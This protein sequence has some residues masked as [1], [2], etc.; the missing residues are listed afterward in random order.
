MVIMDPLKNIPRNKIILVVFAV[1]F[2]QL[3]LSTYFMV[4]QK[5][6]YFADD[7][8]SYG[9]ANSPGIF[10]PLKKD[11]IIVHNEWFNGSILSEYLTVSPDERF[12]FDRINRSLEIDAHP[13]LF[14]YLL[15]AICSLT[16]GVFSNWSAYIINIF[17]FIILQIY[18]YRL[19]LLIGKNRFVAF[20][21]MVFFGFTSAT[22][23]MMVLFRMH[24][25]AT[26]FTV[27]FSFYA[28]RYLYDENNTK[29]LNRDLLLSFVFL[30]L[31]SMT[32]YLSVLFAFFLTAYICLMFIIK[33]N[34]RKM[35]CFGFAMLISVGLMC[36]C[37]PVVF[38]QLFSDLN[39]VEGS[40]LY[41]FMLQLRTCIYVISN[42]VFGIDTP[43]FPS[44]IPFYTLTILI[45]LAVILAVVHF[46]F[47]NDQW[48][49]DLM[50]NMKSSLKSLIKRA[51]P[52]LLSL[53]PFAVIILIFMILYSR[54]LKIFYYK[55]YA[56]RYFYILTPFVAMIVLIILLKLIKPIY[57]RIGIIMILLTTSLLFGSK[58]YLEKE[59]QHKEI[60]AQTKDSDVIVIENSNPLFMYHI[61]DLIDCDRFLY[62]NPKDIV[63]GKVKKPLLNSQNDSI[64]LLVDTDATSLVPVKK[65]AYDNTGTEVSISDSENDVI[66]YFRSLPGFENA[67]L[68]DSYHGCYLYRL[69]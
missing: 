53:L 39:A 24:I 30:Y 34:I 61:M 42:G 41:P 31:S 1:I 19:S 59:L 35:F 8:Y 56:M 44:M 51:H 17:G 55:A 18:L 65:K 37:F 28:L 66:R 23:N 22:V 26:G 54:N 46:I 4:F 45:G 68:I 47:R 9:F 49:K 32:L 58:C 7:L 11:D 48:F 6:G 5:T 27:A 50:T 14:Y 29:V 57:F 13:P 21:I 62:A 38:D 3:I 52:C 33:K 25:L 16:P 63:K 15:H 12:T 10:S 40:D 43:I 20:L 67:A 69:R 2:F 36:L 60:S 64:L